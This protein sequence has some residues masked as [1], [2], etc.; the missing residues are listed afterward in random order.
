MKGLTHQTGVAG[1]NVAVNS[2][3]PPI[4]SLFVPK[5]ILEFND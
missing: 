4:S 5:M 3:G 1:V 2:I